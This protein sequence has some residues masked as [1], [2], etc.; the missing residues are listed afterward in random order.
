M[1]NNRI[2]AMTIYLGSKKIAEVQ[3]SSYDHASNDEQ[4][5]A[6]E[7][8]FGFSDG[9]DTTQVQFQ[10][11]VP[12]QGLEVDIAQ[13]VIDKEDISMGMEVDGGIEKLDGRITTRGYR[14]DNRTGVLTGDFT[15]I[16]GKP[17]RT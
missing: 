5:I 9:A 17:D 15:F 12:I 14:S 2:R 16:G 11:I 3:S 1:A 8:V 10:V 7:G 4:Q 13:M 6:T